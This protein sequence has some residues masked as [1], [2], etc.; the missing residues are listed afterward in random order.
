MSLPLIVMKFGGAALA[1]SDKMDLAARRVCGKMKSNRVIVVVSAMGDETDR[2]LEMT[3]AFSAGRK[4]ADVDTVL[5]GGEQIAAGLM[6][7]A[8][9]HHGAAAR[10]FL[11][12]QLPIVTDS[13]FGDGQIQRVGTRKLLATLNAGVV[14]VVAGFQGIDQEGRLV[15]LGRGGSD[16]SAVAIAAATGAEMCELYK[17]V[18]AIY[19]A[20]PRRVPT[21]ERYQSLSYGEMERIAEREPQILHQKAIRLAKL[22]HIRLHIRSAFVE[23]AGTVVESVIK[24]GQME[25]VSA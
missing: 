8:L 25:E 22:R 11:A 12:H 3:Q 17:D 9:S 10:S 4:L 13:N 19:S 1:T 6:A 14:P 23:M 20:D 2:L 18:D 16:T 5:A 24:N 7:L 15:T 21:A